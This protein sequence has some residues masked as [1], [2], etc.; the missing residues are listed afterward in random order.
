VGR[1]DP[2]PH[3]DRRLRARYWRVGE[4]RRSRG[5][6]GIVAR[7]GMRIAVGI[8]IDAPP[9]AVWAVL[10]PIER[11]VDWMVDAEAI[12]FTTEA[13]RGGGAAL[14]CV[15]RVGPKRLVDHMEVTE[16]EPGRALGIAHQGVVTGRGR[17]T[18][19]PR[20]GGRTRFTWCEELRFPWTMG[21]TAG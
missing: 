4:H 14:D 19:A 9:A 13:T 15:A 12:P 3:R 10:E 18:L 6:G 2:A 21:G 8:T 7:R 20:P 16:W 11:H 17:F 1:R 5:G